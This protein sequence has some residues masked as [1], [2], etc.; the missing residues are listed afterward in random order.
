MKLKHFILLVLLIFSNISCA[1]FKEDAAIYRDALNNVRLDNLDFAF[2]KFRELENNF[3][4]SNYLAAVKFGMA[5][6]L[7]LQGDY[8]NASSKLIEYIK[9]YSQSKAVVFA[10]A[11][12]YKILSEK[13]K[14][15]DLKDTETIKGVIKKHYFSNSIFFIFSEYKTK[16]YYSV[17]GNRYRIYEYVDRI[18]VFK[19]N[20]LFLKVTP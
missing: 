1:I 16:S 8:S 7:F 2:M 19:N 13:M 17:L 10:E 4:T 15:E 12:L 6:Y 20:E 9:E 14:G 3:P 11:I 18:E 5:E